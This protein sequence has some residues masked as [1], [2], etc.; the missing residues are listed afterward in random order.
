MTVS[1]IED[2][3]SWDNRKILKFTRGSLFLADYAADPV[4][5]PFTYDATQTTQAV[6]LKTPLPT[7]FVDPGFITTD[8]VIFSRDLSISDVNSWQSQDPTNSTVETDT[9]SAHVI[10]QETNPYTL[11]LYDNKLLADAGDFSGTYSAPS[12]ASGEQPLRRGFFIAE[13]LDVSAPIW[14]VIFLPQIKLTAIGD[15][16]YQRTQ[17]KQ[18]DYTLTAY[19]DADYGASLKRWVG[20]PGW[21]A[22]APAA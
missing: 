9:K 12:S 16:S 17:E 19:K 2:L 4:T 11:A 15:Q 10:F 6:S 22:L 18:Y 8:G 7:G 5:D 1:T 20:G 13:A 14:E 21:N 3:Q